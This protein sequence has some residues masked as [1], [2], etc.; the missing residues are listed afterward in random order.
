MKKQSLIA[1]LLIVLTVGITFMGTV[2]ASYQ[3]VNEVQNQ[4]SQGLQNMSDIAPK[5]YRKTIVTVIIAIT[6]MAIVILISW[7]YKTN[8]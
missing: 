2:L 1:I 7:W 8:Y 4:L 3:S 6:L 5:D